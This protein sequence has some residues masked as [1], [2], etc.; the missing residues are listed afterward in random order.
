MLEVVSVSE[1]D[2][3]ANERLELATTMAR[4]NKCT[5]AEEAFRSARWMHGANKEFR[6]AHRWTMGRKLA[7]CWAHQGTTKGV[8][9]ARGWDA[10][11][12]TLRRTSSKLANPLCE[13]GNTAFDLEDWEA[14]WS[15]LDRCVRLDPTRAWARRDAEVARRRMLDRAL[16]P[17]PR[18]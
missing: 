8:D 7:E 17:E 6:L 2:R 10:T 15:A 12:P 14:A 9:R 5:E 1:R 18:K 11:S 4:A 13:E 3:R 16:V